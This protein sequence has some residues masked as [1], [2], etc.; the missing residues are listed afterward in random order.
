MLILSRFE[1][2]GLRRQDIDDWLVLRQAEESGARLPEWGERQR[3][4]GEDV[5][6]EGW[7]AA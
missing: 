6:E 2:D 4:G 3:K 7:Y 1:D 5:L